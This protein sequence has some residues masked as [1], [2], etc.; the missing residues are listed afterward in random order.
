MNKS[1]GSEGLD[2]GEITLRKMAL[3]DVE[4]VVEIEKACF[5]NPWTR[6]S[7]E[8]ETL[9]KAAVYIVAQ[10]DGRV[11]AY[12]GAWLV[13]DEAHI[14]NIAVHPDFR[15][16]GF[17]EAVTC[18]LLSRCKNLGIYYAYLEVRVSNKAAI[19]LY[20]KLGFKIL[21]VRKKYYED[22]GEDAYVMFII[23]DDMP[24]GI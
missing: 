10:L 20:K 14:T 4:D 8:K 23:L 16:R 2:Q 9:N 19:G 13:I 22:N 24:L 6:K 15:G 11:R 21:S 17:G 7:V 5:H 12:A 1:M 18:E 3:S